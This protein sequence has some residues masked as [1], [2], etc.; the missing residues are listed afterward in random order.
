MHVNKHAF[1]GEC[2][3]LHEDFL[4]LLDPFVLQINLKIIWSCGV[5]ETETKEASNN[6]LRYSAYRSLNAWLGNKKMGGRKPLPSCVTSYVKLKYPDPEGQYT[7]FV[8]SSPVF[9]RKARK[10]I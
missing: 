9:K 4:K 2:I 8:A 1:T 5:Y 3:C 7:G 6:N 10:N